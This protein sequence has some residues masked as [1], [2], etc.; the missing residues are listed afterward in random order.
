MV[1]TL[2]DALWILILYGSMDQSAPV[3][4]DLRGAALK[5]MSSWLNKSS[6]RL[7][8]CRLYLYDG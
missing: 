4:N 2:A 6:N 7:G 1:V 5:D 3:V 8:F